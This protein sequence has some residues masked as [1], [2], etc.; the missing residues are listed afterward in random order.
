MQSTFSVAL[1]SLNEAYFSSTLVLLN[2]IDGLAKVEDRKL[3]LL[4]QLHIVRRPV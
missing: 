1:N 2:P 4:L 3:L